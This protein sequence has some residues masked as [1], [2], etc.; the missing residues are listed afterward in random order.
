MVKGL[1]VG[2]TVLA[3]GISI[4]VITMF[5]TLNNKPEYHFMEPKISG[6]YTILTWQDKPVKNLEH[7]LIFLDKPEKITIKDTLDV[8]PPLRDENY[9]ILPRGVFHNNNNLLSSKQKTYRMAKKEVK[10]WILIQGKAF[11][12]ELNEAE[13]NSLKNIVNNINSPKINIVDISKSIENSPAWQTI[14]KELADKKDKLANGKLDLTP[15]K[16]RSDF[17]R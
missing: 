4:P 5:I 14:L 7:F 11:S 10:T 13:L 8:V 3:I 9:Y 1:K 12:V 2:L 17:M 16:K 6:A 15:D